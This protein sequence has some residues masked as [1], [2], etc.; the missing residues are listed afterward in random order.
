MTTLKQQLL[1]ITWNEYVK[2][3]RGNEFN[4]LSSEERVS[5]RKQIN[6]QFFLLKNVV[7]AIGQA[8]ALSQ[9]YVLCIS[10]SLIASCQSV[11]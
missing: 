7:M 5:I 2:A 4:P 11:P 8:K 9:T 6:E 1:E 3:V 10:I